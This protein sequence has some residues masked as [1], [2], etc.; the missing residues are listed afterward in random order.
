MGFVP[1]Q[2]ME[3]VF[4]AVAMDDDIDLHPKNKRLP[5]TRL[6]WAASNLVYGNHEL[7]LQGPQVISVDEESPEGR[8]VVTGINV[9]FS[10]ALRTPAL[11][12]D[13]FMVCCMESMDLCDEWN[14]GTEQ[15]WQGIKMVD[16][17]GGYGDYNHYYYY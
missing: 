16:W 8:D 2:L 3:N 14:Y 10:A 11:E 7:P 5:A 17:V 9:T 1:N 6:A 13:R 4:M 15:G 12:A